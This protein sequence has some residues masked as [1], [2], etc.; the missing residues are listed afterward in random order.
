[1]SILLPHSDDELFALPFINKK[2]NEGLK[3]HIFFITT[4]FNA[5]REKESEKM[6]SHFPEVE[7]HHFGKL[8]NIEDSSLKNCR[9]VVQNLLANDFIIKSSE[10]I[11]TTMYEGGHIDHDEVFKIG[12]F[13]SDTLNKPHFSFSLYNAYR[14]PLVRVS[15]FFP[16]PVKGETELIY[17]S[18]AEGWSYLKKVFYYK[19]QFVALSVL[20]SGLFKT[21]ILKRKIEIIKISSFDPDLDHPGKAFYKNKWK[22]RIKTLLRVPTR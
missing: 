15:T 7:V 4:D 11:V 9:D 10:S 19:S 16:G 13:L 5:A 12:V 8:N 6:L 1:M 20:F 2:I 22:D 14:T 18:L 17:F 3:I 21:F